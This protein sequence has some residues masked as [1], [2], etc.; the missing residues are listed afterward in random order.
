MNSILSALKALLPV[1]EPLGEQ[2]VEQLWA[3][4]I[5]PFIAG[6]SDSNDS[7]ALLQC[8]SPGLKQFA[9]LEMKKLK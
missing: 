2:G 8:I 6:L 5:D 9:L 1:I 7:K 3:S 4:V